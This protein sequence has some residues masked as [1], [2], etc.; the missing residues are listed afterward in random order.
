MSPRLNCNIWSYDVLPDLESKEGIH[1]STSS[2]CPSIPASWQYSVTL[3]DEL[4]GKNEIGNTPS[5]SEEKGFLSAQTLIA[6]CSNLLP[7]EEKGCTA[8][9]LG[10]LQIMSLNSCAAVVEMWEKQIWRLASDWTEMSEQTLPHQDWKEK[11]LQPL[12]Y[13][14]T[15]IAKEQWNF[16]H[17][18]SI[19][20]WEW[21][22]PICDRVQELSLSVHLYALTEMVSEPESKIS[23]KKHCDSHLITD[24]LQSKHLHEDGFM[25]DEMESL[26]KLL[27]MMSI[28]LIIQF[29]PEIVIGI[30]SFYGAMQR[31]SVKSFWCLDQC[32]TYVLICSNWLYNE[33]N[34]V[35]FPK[36]RFPTWILSG[37]DLWGWSCLSCKM[38]S[39]P[40]NVFVKM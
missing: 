4:P 26:K 11:L 30:W 29:C 5:F 22:G 13:T 33:M 16:F 15:T 1:C 12:S 6:I 35:N 10:C 8:A 21:T 40:C 39:L 28:G 31:C 7:T 9:V 24:L 32:C 2:V 19:S 14:L 34:P 37:L 25:T 36:E 27:P 38:L 3:Q 17:N 20:A 23:V 18:L